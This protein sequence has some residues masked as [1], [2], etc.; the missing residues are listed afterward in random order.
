MSA[1]VCRS[2]VIVCLVLLVEQR[3]SGKPLRPA[4][5][6]DSNDLAE[7]RT[8]SYGDRLP[9]GAFARL[10][11][12]RLRTEL[13]G[14]SGDAVALSPDGKILASAHEEVHLWD[15][16]TG[17][18]LRR[19]PATVRA[20]AVAFTPD[21]KTLLTGFHD[22]SIQ[23][24]K[25]GTGERLRE[26]TGPT[27]EKSRSFNVGCAFSPDSKR[28]ITRSYPEGFSVWD[29]ASGKR[30][31]H[32]KNEGIPFGYALALSPE[33][34]T[35]AVGNKENLVRLIDAASDSEIRQLEAPRRKADERP[36]V[37]RRWAGVALWCEFS[38][39][40]KWLATAGMDFIH[41]WQARTGNLVKVIK[42]N[43]GRIAF[44]KDGKYLAC[45]HEGAIRLYEAATG[46]PIR[47]FE[48]QAG[49]ICA[50]AF[51]AD[52]RVLATGE[53][54]TVT[55]WHVKTGKRVHDFPGHRGIVN[56]LAF[57]PDGQTLASG[58][59]QVDPTLI[60]WDLARRKP[61]HRIDDYEIDILSVA[62]SPDGTVVATGDGYPR[63]GSGGW[64]AVIRFHR[65]STG[66]LLRQFPAHINS[67]QHLSFSRDGSKLASAGNDAR[68]KV[69]DTRTGKRLVQIRHAERVITAAAL[70][71]DGKSLLTAE[72]QG[73]F[74]LWRVAT[75]RRIWTL[76][77][78]SREVLFAAF[79]PDGKTIVSRE[80]APFQELEF[81]HPATGELVHSF[82]ITSQDGYEPC[83][84]L[85]PDGKTFAASADNRGPG[86]GG[87]RLW[88][89][90]SGQLIAH[91]KGQT[92]LTALAFSPD[93]RTLASGS[94]DT[95]VLLWDVPR[96]RLLGM[97]NWLAASGP[98]AGAAVKELLAYSGE[99]VPFLRQRLRRIAAAEARTAPLIADLDSD[100]FKVRQR[101]TRELE[102]LG[103]EA[104]IGLTITL[105]SKVSPEVASRAQGILTRIKDAQPAFGVA[106]ARRAVLAITVLE[107]IGSGEARRA[108]EELARERP[109]TCLAR[110]ASAALR[111]LE[112][113]G[114]SG[115]RKP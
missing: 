17:K 51:S 68:A 10:G 67:V 1:F 81:W 82:P 75:G 23:H 72:N 97:W 58:G 76:G 20:N 91:L 107:K 73:R 22:G 59:D 87:I 103:P 88:D 64:E 55:L 40:G 48:K 27:N 18:E 114:R 52:G 24:W 26:T 95:T 43:R 41:L 79:L 5:P 112:Q 57:S 62:F 105:Q 70:S 53:D 9:E 85:S 8:D 35:L 46:K 25:V 4:G 113:V 83:Y 96:V 101:A 50:M 77:E 60:L 15:T 49:W 109:G 21:G 89:T 14:G 99:A 71:P 104:R 44:S 36:R 30:N 39:D 66:K 16:G 37:G 2:A 7:G 94:R 84:A 11:T 56:C 78:Y 98:K 42:G 80:V 110:E 29:V 108:L 3:A 45:G 33:G 86:G 90:G 65:V 100:S 61:R 38:P 13:R 111:R 102:R 28:F 92:I 93:S 31:I 69:W 34:R 19:L 32:V 12:L 74:A 6:N 106:D 63:G 54:H 115:R 47:R